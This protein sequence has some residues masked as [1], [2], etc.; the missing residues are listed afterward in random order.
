VF[1]SRIAHHRILTI[2][3]LIQTESKVY[4]KLL[5]RVKVHRDYSFGGHCGEEEH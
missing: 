3:I 1:K 5:A 4:D 2:K